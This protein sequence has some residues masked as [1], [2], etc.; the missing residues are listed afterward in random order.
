MRLSIIPIG[1]GLTL[2]ATLIAGSVPSSANAQ[3]CAVVPLAPGL[4]VCVD[5][6]CAEDPDTGLPTGNRCNENCNCVPTAD[7][8]KCW[9]VKDLKIPKF[10]KRNVTLDDQFADESVEVKKLFLIC[11]PADKDGS[12]INDPD[13]HQCCY[14]I[15]GTKLSPPARVE[16]DDQFGTHT[17]QVQKA[18]FLC[19]P[20][21]KTVLP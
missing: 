2:G 5:S 14:K 7:H 18:K 21:L 1:L 11:A 3:K 12:G 15:K 4:L 6:E 8:F 17:L 19:Q 13:T 9:Q 16:V 20:C 10:D